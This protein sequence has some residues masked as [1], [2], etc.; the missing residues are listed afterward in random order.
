MRT[1]AR[2]RADRNVDAFARTHRDGDVWCVVMCNSFEFSFSAG[3][4]EPGARLCNDVFARVWAEPG[5]PRERFERALVT[6]LAEFRSAARALWTDDEWADGGASASILA[7][8]HDGRLH[9]RW[10][11][12]HAAI[13]VRDRAVVAATEPHTLAREIERHGVDPIGHPQ[14]GILLR[15]VTTNDAHEP[16]GVEWECRAGDHLIVA[17]GD[18]THAAARECRI[19]A[20]RSS[21]PP[22][23]RTRWRSRP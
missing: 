12:E 5:A 19:R 7:V 20:G 18:V 22:S 14:A 1:A 16:D 10:L 11:G 23:V 2:F 13:L 3:W 15:L 4:S 9:V 6:M 17:S 21:T 8:L